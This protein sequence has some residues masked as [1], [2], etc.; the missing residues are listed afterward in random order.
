VLYKTL[1]ILLLVQRLVASQGLGSVEVGR[2]LV[3]HLWPTVH[4]F[5][6]CVLNNDAFIIETM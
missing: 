6:V 5:F 4:L 1:E 2:L 3:S